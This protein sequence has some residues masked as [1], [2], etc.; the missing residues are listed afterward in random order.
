MIEAHEALECLIVVAAGIQSPDIAQRRGGAATECVLSP[1]LGPL[2]RAA[3]CF[4]DVEDVAQ[5]PAAERPVPGDGMAVLEDARDRNA[6]S[7]QR[8]KGAL[9]LGKCRLVVRRRREHK[10]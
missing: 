10:A 2:L 8:F 7:V 3:R 1:G 5:R 9:L 6:V 4:E